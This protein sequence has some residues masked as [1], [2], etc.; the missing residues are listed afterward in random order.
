MKNNH[1]FSNILIVLFVVVV[2]V[3][4]GYFGYNYYKNSQSPS[5]TQTTK[6]EPAQKTESK[7]VAQTE[8]VKPKYKTD[9]I[10]AKD[11]ELEMERKT[12]N[13]P[14]QIDIL[15]SVE[16]DLY[17]KWEPIPSN[18]QFKDYK[19]SRKRLV[20][21]DNYLKNDKYEVLLAFCTSYI[22]KDVTKQAEWGL[23]SASCLYSKSTSTNS[24][25]VYIQSYQN[26]VSCLELDKLGL[27]RAQTIEWK[28]F[29]YEKQV[30][31]K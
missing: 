10:F 14:E 28:C 17:N 3:A 30:E 9:I 2:I 4:G 1:G 24:K 7:P 21:V 15:D 22:T 13:T 27:T 25:W 5:L 18:E 6:Q 16:G 19:F 29:D 11:D 26:P 8:V 12:Q 23:G 31:R 20:K